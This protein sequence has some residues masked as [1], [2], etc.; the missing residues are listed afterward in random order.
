MKKLWYKSEAREWKRGLP[1]GSGRLAAMLWETEECDILSLNHEHLWKGINRG[2]RAPDNAK[3]LPLVRDYL[4]AGK[5]FEAT[6]LSN[7]FFGG[8]GGVSGMPRKLDCFIPAGNLTFRHAAG[9]RITER[10][11][12][13]ETGVAKS[14]RARVN[15]E[16]F[17]DSDGTLIFS[18]IQ[19][20]NLTGELTLSR[21]EEEVA[22]HTFE[23]TSDTITFNCKIVGGISFYVK[24]K[25]MTDGSVTPIANGV[26]IEGASYITTATDVVI[27]E[28][29]DSAREIEP[30]EYDARLI[31]H[32]EKFSSLMARS[33]F[34]IEHEDDLDTLPTDERMEALRNGK[35]DIGLLVL[36]FGYGR[37]LLLSSSICGY[38][39]ANLQGKWNLELDPPWASDY[40]MNINLQMNYWMASPLGMHECNEK[41]FNYVLSLQESGR[42]AA[43]RL[44]GCR[45]IWLSHQGDVWGLQSPESYGWAVWMGTAPWMAMHLWNHYRYM[46]DRKFLEERAYPFFREVALFYED[47]LVRDEN[48]VYQIMPSQSPE[49]RFKGTGCFDVSIG[50]SSAMDIEIA[51]DGLTYAIEA[52]EILGKDKLKVRKW[53]KLREN[54]PKLKVARDGRLVEWDSEEREEV[55]PEHRH[56]SHLY[57]FYPS[58]IINEYDTPELYAAARKSLDTR[59]AAGGGQSG[60][61]RA[62]ASCFFAKFGEGEI[63]GD[64]YNKM[65]TEF[66]TDTLL[67]LHPPGV[68]QIDG[69]LGGT[70]SVIEA[71][72]NVSGGKVRLLHALPKA[73]K[74]GKLEGVYIPG[75]HKLSIFWRDG[76]M[77]KLEIEFGFENEVTF[78]VNGEELKVAREAATKVIEF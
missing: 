24:T 16:F 54:L 36:Y 46:G 64:N 28:I 40:H 8:Y 63:F 41:L 23:V 65:I 39:P 3:F 14:A 44:Y 51:I 9:S 42:D 78:V 1:I 49:N 77:S 60:W 74:S 35:E 57:G 48:G 70:A 25:F 4:K 50:I 71:L 2:R 47:F 13:I 10:S 26:K 12:D 20:E 52:A 29:E 62:W 69:N 73:W 27:P 18:R 45:G 37:Y 33:V 55:E 31:K 72:V 59:L 5:F 75:G 61:S 66:A 17:A 22:E 68:F 34:E 15:S 6:A 43:K 19:G 11:L 53:K 21:E 38:L 67:D 56:V 58:D 30:E 32:K 76:K 7:L